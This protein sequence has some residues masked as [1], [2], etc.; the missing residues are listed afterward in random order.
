MSYNKFDIDKDAE[1]EAAALNKQGKREQA[2]RVQQQTSEY[3]KDK[4]DKLFRGK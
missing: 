4:F 1:R 2:K 3:N